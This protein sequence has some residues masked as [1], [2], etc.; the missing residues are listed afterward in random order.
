M[1]EF[2]VQHWTWILGA[3]VVIVFVVRAVLLL[4]KAKKID[5]EG[6][7]ADAVV[8][9]IVEHYDP[10]NHSSS[11]TT[12]VSYTDRDG[13]TVESPLAVGSSAGYAQGDTLRI[14][15]LPGDRKLVR[16]VK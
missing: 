11:Y 16:E 3:V 8:S 1:K 14:R 13:R 5:R 7:E 12:Y 6:L 10:E 9:R 4:K 15:Y 2:V